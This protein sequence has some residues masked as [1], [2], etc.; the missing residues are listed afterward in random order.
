MHKLK[1]EPY[2]D[3]KLIAT[4]SHTVSSFGSTLQEIYDDGFEVNERVDMLLASD[5]SSATAIS[6]GLGII[7]I[8]GALSRIKPDLIVVLGDRYEAIAAAQSAMMLNIPIAHIHGGEST[9]GLIDEAIRHSITKMSH[10]H[11]VAA[12]KY[13]QR[14]QQLGEN[15]KNIHVVGATGLDNI[16]ETEFIETSEIQRSIG[17]KFY[18]PIF[19]VTYHP[20]TLDPNPM[21]KV[22]ELLNALEFFKDA[23]IV[24]T[25]SNADPNGRQID[26]KIKNFCKQL[27]QKRV[28]TSNLGFRRYLSLMNI[29]NVV[30]GNSSSGLVEAPSIGVPTVNIG[31]RQK[32]RL[33]A[34]SVIDV[35]EVSNQII[36]GINT[37]L[38]PKMVEVARER[39]NP[40]GKPGAAQKIVTVFKSLNQSDLLM[41]K[42]YDVKEL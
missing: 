40:Y 41:K 29:A 22:E 19:L 28:H 31:E 10:L 18:D 13:A 24:F 9:E 20:L 33:R 17:L 36:H 26:D 42:F 8:S 30:I 12:E 23:T 3:L 39:I 32:G 27:P 4:G 37:A 35:D 7:G 21:R 2:F 25:G 14:V 34:P 11:F 6:L 1:A 15:I 5:S 38:S 16:A